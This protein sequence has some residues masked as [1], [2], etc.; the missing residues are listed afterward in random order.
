MKNLGFNTYV[1]WNGTYDRNGGGNLIE[2]IASGL[3]K[4]D[5]P[6][7]TRLD[8]LIEWSEA[9]DMSMV[10]VI[11]PHDYA[12]ENID[13]WPAKWQLNPYNTIVSSN[14]Y[15][16]D[17]ASWNYQQKQYRYIIALGLQSGTVQLADG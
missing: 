4:Y 17:E 14:N 1:Y 12:S 3:G 16:S 10:L 13:G 15:Y 11:L 6:K 8:T 5:Q 2:S 9:R 7:C